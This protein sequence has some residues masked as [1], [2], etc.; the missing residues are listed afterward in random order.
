MPTNLYGPNDNFDKENSHV[1]P[2]LIRRFHEAKL[3]GLTEV[4]IWGTGSPL[5]EFLYVDDLADAALH[6]MDIQ[7]INFDALVPERLSHINIG[8][9]R[10]SKINE[11][12]KMISNVVGYDGNI[13]YDA[14]KPDGTPRKLLDV[15]LAKEL[16]W[17]SK[18]ELHEGLVKTY[19]WFKR[20]QKILR[21]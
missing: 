14:T 21:R 2:A 16:G 6:I 18:V 19:E 15:S 1:I 3:L 10:D 8:T 7:K 4:L 20:N 17:E 11:I 12:A 13:V 5:R 9:G